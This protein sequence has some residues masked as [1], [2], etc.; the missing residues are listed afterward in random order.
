MCGIAG[1][2]SKSGSIE[3]SLGARLRRDAAARRSRA[4]PQGS[5]FSQ[6]HTSSCKVSLFSANEPAPPRS[7]Q[8]LNGMFGGKP[9]ARLARALRRPP[10]PA[11]LEAWFSGIPDGVMSVGED[12]DLTRTNPRR[13]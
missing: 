8:E 11:D 2:F 10:P 1:L 13:P 6:P 4:Q 5:R 7:T 3:E 12:G 9:E